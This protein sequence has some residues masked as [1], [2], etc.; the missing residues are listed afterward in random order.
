[1]TGLC[2]PCRVEHDRWLDYRLA[3]APIRLITIGTNRVQ[4]VVALR[5]LRFEQWRE[6][7]RTQQD[8]I[9]A[10]CAATCGPRT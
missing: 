7:V 9:R 4:D 1:M 2:P 3:P 5:G 8:L 6:T 10:G